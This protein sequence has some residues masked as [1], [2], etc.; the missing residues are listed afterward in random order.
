M[1]PVEL[2]VFVD[3]ELA[4]LPRPTA[5]PSLVPRILSAVR[6][7]Q[8]EPWHRRPWRAWPFTSRLAAGL[9]CAGLAL[10]VPHAWD[11]ITATAPSDVLVAAGAVWRIVVQP[12]A[13]YL[14]AIGVAMFVATAMC[15]TALA[16]V[17]RQGGP[18]YEAL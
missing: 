12:A 10:V 13:I 6:Q 9:L 14:A 5:P 8:G 11:A 4:R 17:L 1:T 3:R 7:S 16:L 18:N 2:E 15:C